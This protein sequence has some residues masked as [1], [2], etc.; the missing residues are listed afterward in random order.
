VAFRPRAVSREVIVLFGLLQLVEA[1]LLFTFAGSRTMALVLV[2]V[3]VCVMIGALLWPQILP[4]ASSLPVTT[5]S[6]PSAPR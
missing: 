4:L 1:V 2:A 3:A 6:V 5:K